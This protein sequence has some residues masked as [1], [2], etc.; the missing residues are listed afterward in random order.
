MNPPTPDTD[1]FDEIFNSGIISVRCGNCGTDTI[2]NAAYARYV[3]GPLLSCRHCRTP[4]PP[5]T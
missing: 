1:P 4:G 3:P 2:M 5:R